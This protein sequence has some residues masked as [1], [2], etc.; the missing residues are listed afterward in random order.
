M[1]LP[2][3]K[4]IDNASKKKE[5]EKVNKFEIEWKKLLCKDY[6]SGRESNLNELE[7]TIKALT[8][9]MV[10]TCDLVAIV[11]DGNEIETPNSWYDVMLALSEENKDGV[12]KQF[13]SALS[14]IAE[15]AIRSE[16]VPSRDKTFIYKGMYVTVSSNY[17]IWLENI[18]KMMIQLD[19]GEKQIQF[20]LRRKEYI[21]EKGFWGET[22]DEITEQEEQAT[23]IRMQIEESQE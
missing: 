10:R 17:A 21:E 9:G 2:T 7:V 1:R 23:L 22:K 11:V 18:A 16:R 13:R 5:K 20:K 4:K 14:G 3:K 8:C 6:T 19:I 15:S 12:P